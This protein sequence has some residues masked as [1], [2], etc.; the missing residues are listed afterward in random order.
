MLDF[1]NG[2]QFL[3]LL[4]IL[5][6]CVICANFA[7]N[8]NK[9][10]VISNTVFKTDT[11]IKYVYGA[12]K[13]KRVINKI[14]R[15]NDT[16]TISDTFIVFRDRNINL[17][18]NHINSDTPIVNYRIKQLTIKDSIFIKQPYKNSFGAGAI[19]S[20]KSFTP[21]VTF[22]TQKCNYL[23]GY[24]VI[25]KQPNFGIIINLSNIARP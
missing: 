1:K 18:V 14:I 15:V 5:I 22:S 6:T 3:G 7:C 8:N 13:A 2:F 21:V 20:I 23:A 25:N 11:V 10:E 17:E 9:K 4:L 19:T 24:D 12:G 16:V